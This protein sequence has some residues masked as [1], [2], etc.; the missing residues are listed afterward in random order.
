MGRTI[1]FERRELTTDGRGLT[2]AE[3][4][5]GMVVTITSDSG[6]QTFTLPDARTL[7]AVAEH[8]T[9]EVGYEGISALTYADIGILPLVR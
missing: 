2:L 4:I 3:P 1:T 5:R 8:F 9:S 6:Y 7:R